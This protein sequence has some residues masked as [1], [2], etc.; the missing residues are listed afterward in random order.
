MNNLSD[1]MKIYQ[2][3]LDFI[4]SGKSSEDNYDSSQQP[5]FYKNN[6]NEAMI[7]HN[8]PE[9][10]KIIENINLPSELNK[11]YQIIGSCNKEYYFNNWTLLSLN[12]A[13]KIYQD[14]KNNNQDKIFDFAIRYVGMGHIVVASINLEDSGIIYR[15]DGGSNG[16]EREENYNFIKSYQPKFSNKTIYDWI[17]ET[18]KIEKGP[19]EY[20]LINR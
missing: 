2:E 12:K 18:K 20:S 1:S 13:N 17:E 4:K 9:V 10:N 5:F 16:Y 7:N 14:L 8:T 6:V 11:I 15:A 19:F 3:L